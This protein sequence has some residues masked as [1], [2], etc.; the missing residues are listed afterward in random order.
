MSDIK[1]AISDLHG[2]IYNR[3]K[4][5][6][7]IGKVNEYKPHRVYLVGDIFD[8]LRFDWSEFL[9]NENGIVFYRLI[10]EIANLIK[11]YGGIIY[12]VPGNH[13]SDIIKY[14]NY[15]SPIIIT[16]P[17]F[18][19][20]GI[21]FVHGHQFDI[22]QKWLEPILSK[23]KWLLPSLYRKYCGTPAEL[24]TTNETQ[25]TIHCGAISQKILNKARAED[26]NII[27][28]HTHQPKGEWTPEGQKAVCCGDMQ[29]ECTYVYIEGDNIEV[30]KL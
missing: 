24:K 14:S 18:K 2:Y 3:D 27:Y 28:G 21:L 13:D 6:A 19:D 9:T 20:Y 7:F 8:L 4:L 5:L 12:Y 29:T 1:L 22:T 25:Y 10:L 17:E 16:V 23:F 11:N 30:R 15:L 26:I